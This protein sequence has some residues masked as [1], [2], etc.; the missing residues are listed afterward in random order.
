M[1]RKRSRKRTM[2]GRNECVPSRWGPR[3]TYGR[4]YRCRG[5]GGRW[6]RQ[7]SCR[8]CPASYRGGKAPPRY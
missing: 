7:R 6:V 4:G 8:R 1:P 3:G 2:R 5:R